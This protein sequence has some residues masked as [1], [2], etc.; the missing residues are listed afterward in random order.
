MIK[1]KKIRFEVKLQD[2]WIGAFWKTRIGYGW[3]TPSKFLT[4]QIWICFVPC[5]PLYL[6]LVRQ[7]SFNKLEIP[8]T[9]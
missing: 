6:E 8:R 2:F 1:V 5:F 9:R 3:S 4:I 7:L